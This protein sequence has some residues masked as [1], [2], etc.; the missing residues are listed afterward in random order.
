MED[1]LSIPVIL[2]FGHLSA[3]MRVLFPGPHPRSI[4]DRTS[5]ADS[6][7][8]RSRHGCVRS[9]PNFKYWPAFQDGITKEMSHKNAQI[10]KMILCILCI[11]KRKRDSAQPQ[12]CG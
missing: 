1:E 5:P 7:A 6:R 2:A 10:H 9:S 4:M 8:A 3:R 12:D 11:A